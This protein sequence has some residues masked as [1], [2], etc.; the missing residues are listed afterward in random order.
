MENF[1]K[2]LFE[3]SL[4]N[5]VRIVSSILFGLI[6]AEYFF[7]TNKRKRKIEYIL[8]YGL[9]FLALN[10]I[11]GLYIGAEDQMGN[12]TKELKEITQLSALEMFLFLILL[13][14]SFFVVIITL[15]A[16]RLLKKD[17]S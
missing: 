15:K 4:I 12:F 8:A 14:T 16:L 1:I 7:F 13:I 6:T 3:P 11:L 2:E 17:Y 10:T 5:L 9:I